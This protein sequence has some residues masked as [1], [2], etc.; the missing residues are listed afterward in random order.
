MNFRRKF[1]KGIKLSQTLINGQGLTTGDHE[2]LFDGSPMVAGNLI[3]DSGLGETINPV[4]SIHTVPKHVIVTDKITS[5]YFAYKFGNK[6]HK[7][8]KES[9]QYRVTDQFSNPNCMCSGIHF[10]LSQPPNVPIVPS[11]TSF[12]M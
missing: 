10:S 3:R 11:E 8:A 4:S 1:Q 2:H 12:E 6:N 7:L 5:N 9:P